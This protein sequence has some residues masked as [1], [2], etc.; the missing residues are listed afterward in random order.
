MFD[1]VFINADMLPISDEEKAEIGEGHE[2][3]TKDYENML[4]EIYITDDG[5]LKVSQFELEEVPKKERPYPD[6]EGILGLMGSLKR[7]HERLE[8]LPYHGFINFYGSIN[9]KWYSFNAKF[10][11]GK[12]I[13][14]TK[15]N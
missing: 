7:I 2:W 14:I 3:Q 12:L 10:T 9:K 11:D 4:T 5:L 8:V 1:N 6:G 15:S 13:E